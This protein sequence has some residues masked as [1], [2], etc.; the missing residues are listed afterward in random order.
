MLSKK[1][2][3]GL[4]DEYT[5]VVISPYE[6]LLY[7]LRPYQYCINTTLLNVRSSTVAVPLALSVLLGDSV[8]VGSLLFTV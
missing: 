7:V 2:R 5:S 4:R 1:P 6:C 8:C 3:P